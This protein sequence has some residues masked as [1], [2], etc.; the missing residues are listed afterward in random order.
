MCR[1]PYINIS[2][3]HSRDTSNISTFISKIMTQHRNIE[4]LHKFAQIISGSI[5]IV[6]TCLKYYLYLNSYV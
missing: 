6:H 4:Q 5:E 1:V 3:A 2:I